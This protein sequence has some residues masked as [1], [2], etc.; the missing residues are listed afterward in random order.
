LEDYGRLRVAKSRGPRP[1][2]TVC[3]VAEV[4]VV[5]MLGE[6]G[7]VYRG[8]CRCGGKRWTALLNMWA[9]SGDVLGKKK[10]G[11]GKYEEKYDPFHEQSSFG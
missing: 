4:G 8:W 7:L 1:T 10:R 5:I 6:R 3:R 9:E 2:E 11:R